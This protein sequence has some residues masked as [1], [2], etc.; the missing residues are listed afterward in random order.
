MLA[1]KSTLLRM[2]CLSW[3]ENKFLGFSST[4]GPFSL[5]TNALSSPLHMVPLEVLSLQTWKALKLATKDYWQPDKGHLKAWRA[6]IWKASTDESTSWYDPSYRVAT[7]S[8]TGNPARA[9]LLI[10]SSRPLVTP[11]IYSLGTCMDSKIKSHE[12][13]ECMSSLNSAKVK[14]GNMTH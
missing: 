5:S 3:H 14:V 11:G 2:S 6:A 10:I 8:T 13:L 9:P 4:Y 7:R 12:A 1:A